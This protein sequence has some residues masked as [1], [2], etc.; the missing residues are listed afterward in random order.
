M[1]CS[2]CGYLLKENKIR[3]VNS[4]ASEFKKDA[5]TT[6]ACP[7]CGHLI[8]NNLNEEEVKSLSRAAHSEIHRSR[9][10]LNSGLCFLAISVI[11]LVISFMFYLM[12]FKAAAGGKLVTTST[13]FYVFISLLVIG[14][15]ALSYSI[16][17]LTRGI[18]KKKTYTN[19]LK[20]IQRETFIQ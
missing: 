1:F 4:Q 9:N 12:S 11:L 7:R 17:N 18:L 15:L 10:L 19:L 3:K 2:H 6:Y 5:I 20:D 8:K 16:F 13:E 14:I